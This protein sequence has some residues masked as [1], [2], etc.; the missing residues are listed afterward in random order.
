VD[1]R[2]TEHMQELRRVHRGTCVPSA[3]CPCFQFEDEADL[4]R[5]SKEGDAAMARLLALSKRRWWQFWK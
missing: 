1:A 5:L 2:V 3:P 4:K